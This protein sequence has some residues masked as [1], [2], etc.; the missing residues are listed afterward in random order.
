MLGKNQDCTCYNQI[1]LMEAHNVISV[2]HPSN[3][4]DIM[5]W[6]YRLGHPNFVYLK[7][8]FSLLFKN[9]NPTLFQCEICQFS[10]HFQSSFPNLQYKQ[11]KPFALIYNDV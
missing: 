7:K 8:L 11:S 4:H 3:N 5:L 2:S 1:L 9:K 6:H 10:K